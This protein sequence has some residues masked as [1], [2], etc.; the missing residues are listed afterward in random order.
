MPGINE[1]WSLVSG[2][3]SNPP[4][5]NP[6]YEPGYAQDGYYAVNELSGVQPGLGAP[7]TGND[8]TSEAA[9]YF[10]EGQYDQQQAQHQYGGYDRIR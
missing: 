2:T 4:R 8:G 5:N 7:Y 10:Y 6:A 9:E 1:V 3:R